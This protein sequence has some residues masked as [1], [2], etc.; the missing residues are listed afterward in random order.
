MNELQ[1][2]RAVVGTR[3]YYVVYLTVNKTYIF[4]TSQ[5]NKTIYT[6]DLMTQLNAREQRR[7]V[8][9]LLY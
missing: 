6:L 4:R 3:T 7:K 2:Q 1:G 5:I 9:P 8:T